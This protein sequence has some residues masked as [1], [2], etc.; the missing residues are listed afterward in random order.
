MAGHAR[1][2]HV[3]IGVRGIQEGHPGRTHGFHAGVDVIGEQGD[4]L[5]ALAVVLAQVFVDLAL[6]VG[7]LV[8][9]DA[10]DAVRRGH[11]L[12]HQAGLGALD[13]EVADLAE[14]EQA[15]VVVRPLLHVAHEQVVGQVVDE[16]Q[17]KPHR[18]LVHVLQRRE[19]GIQVV[20]AVI[21][22]VEHA[23]ADAGDHRGVDRT[24][25]IGAGKQLATIGQGMGL[26]LFRRGLEADRKTTC[27]RP[28]GSGEI[29][30]KALA[31][32]V[33]QEVDGA[34]AEQ[35]DGALAVLGN[36]G[37]TQLAQVVGHGRG[38]AGGGGE[39]DEFKAVD[40]HRVVKGGDNHARI[41]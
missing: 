5:D 20:V 3:E 15:L 21:D 35:G 28:V 25:R 22:Q 18:V 14:V 4:V 34:L 8:E 40:A 39:F 11:C 7:G 27:R 2:D 1:I 31:F 30:G 9:R 16:G 33:E 12:G 13:V 23:V 10:H 26:Y 41:G 19:V 17:A 6:V 37:E 38:V 36:G 24:L 29:G 32:L